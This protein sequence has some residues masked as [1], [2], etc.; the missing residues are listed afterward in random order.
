MA[1]THLAQFP[2]TTPQERE[3]FMHGMVW[4]GQTQRERI[5]PMQGKAQ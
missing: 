3:T 1:H 2:L 4:L 5:W